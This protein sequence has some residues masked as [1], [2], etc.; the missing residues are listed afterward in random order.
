MKTMRAELAGLSAENVLLR[1]SVFVHAGV[2][3]V[4]M[5]ERPGGSFETT[6][7]ALGFPPFGEPFPRL[8]V[9][10]TN[11]DFECEVTVEVAIGEKTASAR[12]RL[13]GGERL[14]L[15]VDLDEAR[16]PSSLDRPEPE[17]GA[18]LRLTIRGPEYGGPRRLYISDIRLEPAGSQG[19]ER[20]ARP[21]RTS[22]P[23]D[24]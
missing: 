9:E 2:G 7:R 24:V 15:T 1:D 21:G 17:A 3:L 19:R 22:R 18:R 11:A 20:T 4:L 6:F 10:L 14:E 23:S 5:A 13:D 8:F 12:R 16:G